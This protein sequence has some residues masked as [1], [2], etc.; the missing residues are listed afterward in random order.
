[1]QRQLGKVIVAGRLP[2]IHMLEASTQF[3]LLSAQTLL[4]SKYHLCYSLA[5]LRPCCVFCGPSVALLLFVL[6]SMLI[7]KV[8]QAALAWH[9][10]FGLRAL[11]TLQWSNAWYQ[12]QLGSNR[13]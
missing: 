1:M 7:G 6:V 10:L 4:F 2:H 11:V 9:L 3:E 13:L 8:F 5:S 12:E